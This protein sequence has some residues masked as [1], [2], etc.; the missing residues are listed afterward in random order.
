M[1]E[2]REAS[3]SAQESEKVSRTRALVRRTNGKQRISAGVAAVLLL[4]A[5][6]GGL[7]AA[8]PPGPG[9][10]KAG[11][12]FAVGPYDVKIRKVVTVADLAPSISPEQKGDRLLVLVGT[13]KN[14]GKRPE[15]A[16]LLE[17]AVSV[18]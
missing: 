9:K 18:H 1:S 3:E 8:Q 5:P 12:V 6:F 4:T 13:V 15:F 11:K 14:P 7:R 10:L 16:S 17:G 2:S